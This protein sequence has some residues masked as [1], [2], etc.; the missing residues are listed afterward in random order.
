VG[1]ERQVMDDIGRLV[2]ERSRLRSGPSGDEQRQRL[3]LIE[4]EVARCWDRVRKLRVERRAA[5]AE[6]WR[7]NQRE[8]AADAR[9]A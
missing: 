5:Q 9:R 1:D 4:T 3:E 7:S 2:A 6:R 8:Q